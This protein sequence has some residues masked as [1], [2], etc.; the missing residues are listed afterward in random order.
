MKDLNGSKK[1][2]IDAVESEAKQ[3]KWNSGNPIGIQEI[4]VK[5]TMWSR[6]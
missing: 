2:E 6:N 3:Y 5:F 4:K 1:G